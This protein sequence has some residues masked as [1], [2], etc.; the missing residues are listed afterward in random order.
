[1]QMKCVFPKHDQFPEGASPQRPARWPHYERDAPRR[2]DYLSND[3]LIFL[4]LITEHIRNLQQL[5]CSFTFWN[6]I[7]IDSKHKLYKYYF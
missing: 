1:M 4:C 7:Q 5:W 3:H 6:F 2:R